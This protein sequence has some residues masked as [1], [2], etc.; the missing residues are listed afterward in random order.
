M[1][2][3][4][5]VKVEQVSKKYCTS[6][7][8]SLRYG[9]QDIANELKLWGNGKQATLRPDE[10]WALKDV[11]FELRR[12]EAI[13]LI[14]A[15]GAGKSTL[16]KLLNGLIKPDAGQ[17]TMRGRVG[18]LIELGAGFNPVLT[19]R[20]NIYI[21]AAVLGQSKTQVDGVIDDIID[22]S[23]I[24]EFIDTP[25]RN[26][27]SGMWMRL[28]YAIAAHL[29]PDVLLVDEV[30]TVGDLAF[31]RKCLQ[32]MQTY[33]KNG[34]SL[35]L[36]SHSIY[37]L[38]SIC[39]RALFINRGEVAFDGPAV[40]AVELYFKSLQIENHNPVENQASAENEWD[41]LDDEHP[42][43]IDKVEM[44]PVHGDEIRSGENAYITVHYRS[45]KVIDDVFWGFMIWTKDQFVC[46]TGDAIGFSNDT[47]QVIKGRGQFRCTLPR[48]PLI[49]G[50]YALKALI[51]DSQTRVRLARFGWEN[52]PAFF[53]VSSAVSE[54]NNLLA[55]NGT[56]VKMDVQWEK[57]PQK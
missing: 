52:S 4:V 29:N 2:N 7:K 30:L 56:L 23:G 43:A 12:G 6:L 44:T 41:E 27:S 3:D 49:A 26:Y 28:G 54:V 39:Q 9:V 32:H 40:E 45:I 38:Q 25:V 21:N 1:N 35:I 48:L 31:R 36:V 22:F 19:G 14:G 47:Y 57:Q 34:G 53:T 55:L 8:R 16:L 13:G 46:I 10:F 50:S 42:I 18:A 11:S 15:N 5:L 17:I 24:R 33:L 51:G 20:E 37:L